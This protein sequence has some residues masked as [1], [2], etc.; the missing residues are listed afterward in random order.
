VDTV[1]GEEEEKEEETPPGS[2]PSLS[3]GLLSARGQNVFQRES[4]SLLG[5]RREGRR[6]REKRGGG[7]RPG[8]GGTAGGEERKGLW[9]QRPFPGPHWCPTQRR[10]NNQQRARGPPT[11]EEEEEEEEEEGTGTQRVGEREQTREGQGDAT[12]PPLGNPSPLRQ[13]GGSHGSPQAPPSPEEEEDVE[14]AGAPESS[15]E[16]TDGSGQ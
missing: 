7:E 1:G 13:S 5:S 9:G 8:A 10:G 3:K 2:Q 4:G 15:P 6:E 12:A 14:Q 11:P 16:L